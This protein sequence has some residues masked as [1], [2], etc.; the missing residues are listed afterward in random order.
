MDEREILPV[1][2]KRRTLAGRGEEAAPVVRAT[3]DAGVGTEGEGKAGVGAVN[4]VDFGRGVRFFCSTEPA[5][6]FLAGGITLWCL[7]LETPQP[8]ARRP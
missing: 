4:G 1:D 8:T 3:A 5:S 6:V 2:D 7:Q